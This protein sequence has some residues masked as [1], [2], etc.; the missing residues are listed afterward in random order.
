MGKRIV[1]SIRIDEDVLRRAK[2]V[3]L[4]ISKISENALREAIARLETPSH[5]STKSRRVLLL[6]G[7][8]DGIRTHEPSECKSDALPLSYRP[9]R[10]Q[11]RTLI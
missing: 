9:Y 10:G 1:T 4:N 5:T 11:T 2:E 7:G 8:P 3:G 6:E